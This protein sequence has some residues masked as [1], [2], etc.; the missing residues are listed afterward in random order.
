MKRER[1]KGQK[2]WENKH[3]GVEKKAN[4]KLRNSRVREMGFLIGT[5][6]RELSHLCDG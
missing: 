3:L 6:L 5:S 4:E 2:F 1:G